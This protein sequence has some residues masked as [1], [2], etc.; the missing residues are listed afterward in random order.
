[1]RAYFWP[2]P[3]S[4]SL[5]KIEK[6]NKRRTYH[7]SVLVLSY[8][9]TYLVSQNINTCFLQLKKDDA[10][11]DL[12]LTILVENLGRINYARNGQKMDNQKKGLQGSVT[13]AGQALSQWQISPMEFETDEVAKLSATNAGWTTNLT[14][15]QT[16]AAFRIKF[17]TP[18]EPKDTFLN[19]HDWGKGVVFVNGRNIGRYWPSAGPQKTL[20][21][22]GVWLKPSGQENDIILFELEKYGTK[23]VFQ[24]T[25]DLGPT[26]GGSVANLSAMTVIAALVTGLSKFLVR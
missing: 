3:Y 10:N 25:H 15:V 20:Y 7:F 26:A 4:Q 12:I 23:V 2:Y 8:L 1:M 24:N 14:N 22:P 13:F 6:F 16:P 9:T 19:V 11:K 18:E 17:S 21:V 5:G